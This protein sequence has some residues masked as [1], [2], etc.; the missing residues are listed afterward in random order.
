MWT[1]AE[2][3]REVLGWEGKYGVEEVA[4]AKEDGGEL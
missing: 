2:G 4:I 1:E 3:P